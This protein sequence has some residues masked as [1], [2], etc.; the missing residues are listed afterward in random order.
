MTED[1]RHQFRMASG[2][3]AMSITDALDN[4]DFLDLARESVG[5]TRRLVA[6]LRES[7]DLSDVTICQA[8]QSWPVGVVFGEEEQ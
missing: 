2:Q 5:I 6:H 1:E 4:D 3:T 8:L 7:S